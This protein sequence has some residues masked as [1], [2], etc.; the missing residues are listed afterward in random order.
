MGMNKALLV[1]NG[2]TLLEQTSAVLKQICDKVFIIGSRQLYGNFGECYE[3]VYQN[4]GPLA[5]IHAAL[6]NS[7]TRHNLVLAVDTPFV[8]ARFL[9]YLVRRALDSSAIVTVPSIRGKVQPLSAVYSRDFLPL[10]EAALK[11]D[12][13]KVESAFPKER[14]LMLTERDMEEFEMAAEMFENLN[15]PED[16]ERARRRS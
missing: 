5:G 13:Y 12:S 1:L 16:L 14:T 8:S 9:N 7:Q 3:D 2:S 6:L 11:S 10:A 4:C 15:T